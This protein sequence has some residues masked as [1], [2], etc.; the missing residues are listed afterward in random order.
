MQA[1]SAYNHS[2]TNATSHNSSKALSSNYGGGSYGNSDSV[3]FASSNKAA[4]KFG[5][6]DPVSAILSCCGCCIAIPIAGLL[7]LGFALFKK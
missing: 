7:A 1:V 2:P 4:P 6:I 5:I 3:A